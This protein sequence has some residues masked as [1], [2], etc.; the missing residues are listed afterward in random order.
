MSMRF[1]GCIHEADLRASV[2][3]LIVL[4]TPTIMLSQ[5][6]E[7]MYFRYMINTETYLKNVALKHMPP[8]LQKVDLLRSGKQNILF[9]DILRGCS[10][11]SIY[12]Q[13]FTL[14]SQTWKNM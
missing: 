13:V 5:Q 9:S 6:F 11:H 10:L 8:N 12:L 14:F 2:F 7:F 1:G 4:V 3:C